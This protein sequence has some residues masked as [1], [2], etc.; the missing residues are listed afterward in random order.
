[1]TSLLEIIAGGKKKNFSDHSK[2]GTKQEMI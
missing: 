1:M 2:F